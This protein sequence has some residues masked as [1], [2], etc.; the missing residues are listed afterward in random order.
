MFHR[1]KGKRRPTYALQFQTAVSEYDAACSTHGG[2]FVPSIDHFTRHRK[3]DPEQFAHYV[4]IDRRYR[5]SIPQYHPNPGPKPKRIRKKYEASRSSFLAC[6]WHSQTV[7]TPE[8]L[9]SAQ[10]MQPEKVNHFKSKRTYPPGE[11]PWH[12][13]DGDGPGS[14][15]TPT[16]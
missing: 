9:N 2:S 16:G 12:V 5:P 1:N 10:N 8:L 4:S 11:A 3:I 15:T 6:P 13:P 7:V 14:I